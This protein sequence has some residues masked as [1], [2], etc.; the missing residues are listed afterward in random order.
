MPMVYELSRL[1]VLFAFP[2]GCQHTLHVRVGDLLD[3]APF[4][5]DVFELF[6]TF[7]Q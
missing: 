7:V 3:D 2:L 1:S 4:P 5:Q 6:F